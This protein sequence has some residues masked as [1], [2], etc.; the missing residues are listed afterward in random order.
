MWLLPVPPAASALL[1]ASSFHGLADVE[2]LVAQRPQRLYPY[3]FTVAPMPSGAVTPT[4]LAASVVHFSNDVGMVLSAL[5]HAALVVLAAARLHTIAWALLNAY[6]CAVHVPLHLRRYVA[7]G[8]DRRILWLSA[9]A[10]L[11]LSALARDTTFV[12]HEWMQKMVVAH[13]MVDHSSHSS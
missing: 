13:V 8:R 11:P 2:H 1:L 9:A 10:F 7:S 12:V 3:L 5:L 6:M 4:F